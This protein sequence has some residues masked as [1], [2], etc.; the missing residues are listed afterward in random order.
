MTW[1]VTDGDWSIVVMN[2]DGSRG[3]N[4]GVSAGASV[5]FLGDA[6]WWAIGGGTVLFV[7]AGA[8]ILLGV[9][10]PRNTPTRT[11]DPGA[12]PVAA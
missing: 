10:T 12:V 8:L 1:K 11:D 4:A 9:R 7:T 5:P 3:V 2:A 6:A